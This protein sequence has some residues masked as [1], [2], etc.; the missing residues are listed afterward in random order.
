MWNEYAVFNCVM[1]LGSQVAAGQTWW[2]RGC[3]AGSYL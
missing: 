1:V 3:H 2:L